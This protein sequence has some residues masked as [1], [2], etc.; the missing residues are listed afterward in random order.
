MGWV[1]NVSVCLTS[2]ADDGG[3]GAFYFDLSAEMDDV[4]FSPTSHLS[5]AVNG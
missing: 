5:V 4:V 1:N 2:A 3:D